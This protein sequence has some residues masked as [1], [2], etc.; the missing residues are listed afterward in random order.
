MA[1][2]LVAEKENKKSINNETRSLSQKLSP[3]HFMKAFVY[4]SMAEALVVRARK[5]VNGEK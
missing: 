4:F 2:N 3:S 5:R 1:I